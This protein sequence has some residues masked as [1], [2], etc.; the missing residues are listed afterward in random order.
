M[1]CKVSVLVHYDGLDFNV[2]IEIIVTRNLGAKDFLLNFEKNNLV[3]NIRK[4]SLE[5]ILRE[6][7]RKT[8]PIDKWQS[9][10][11]TKFAFLF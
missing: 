6:R 10:I 1:L 4:V 5:S 8:Q 3:E 9:S 2:S 11:K 7:L